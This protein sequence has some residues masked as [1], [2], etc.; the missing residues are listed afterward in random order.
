[1]P[2]SRRSL[3]LR[4]PHPSREAGPGPGTPSPWDAMEEEKQDGGQ[5]ARPCPPAQAASA[6]QLKPGWCELS[7]RRWAGASPRFSSGASS[8]RLHPSQV[9]RVSASQPIGA[10]GR[11]PTTGLRPVSAWSRGAPAAT[12]PSVAATGSPASRANVLLPELSRPRE[13]SAHPL[14]A[15][16]G[17]GASLNPGLGGRR[18]GGRK[19]CR[20]PM[21]VLFPVCLLPHCLQRLRGQ[22]AAPTVLGWDAAVQQRPRSGGAGDPRGDQD[23]ENLATNT[24]GSI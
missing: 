5:A 12:R 17:R 15:V 2:G 11:Y 14:R 19:Q 7:T 4:G 8:P 22:R 3:R 10:S 18:G 24:G 6:S 9:S 1:M 13:C 16:H 23:T 21:P 20:G